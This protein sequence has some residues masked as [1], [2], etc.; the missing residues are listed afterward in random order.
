MDEIKLA[1]KNRKRLIGKVIFNDRINVFKISVYREYFTDSFAINFIYFLR[2]RVIIV[3]I[4]E[5]LL[6]GVVQYDRFYI[7]ILLSKSNNK[8]ITA[9]N[10][11]FIKLCEENVDVR[12]YFYCKLATQALKSDLINISDIN[13][14][15]KYRYYDQI[16]FE[17]VEYD[18]QKEI[19]KINKE[20]A[21]NW[22]K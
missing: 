20:N 9:F 6:K 19:N 3:Y 18:F 14:D 12:I 13:Y 2:A 10:T 7:N 1:I 17:D 4:L 11:K 21:K 5:C 16:M 22:D 15:I 8:N